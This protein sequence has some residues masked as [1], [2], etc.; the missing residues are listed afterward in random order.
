M[1]LHTE[2]YCDKRLF[3]IPYLNA[4]PLVNSTLHDVFFLQWENHLLSIQD[5][6]KPVANAEEWDNE[7]LFQFLVRVNK[8]AIYHE[9]CILLHIN[10]KLVQ[11]ILVQTV[12]QLKLDYLVS[13]YI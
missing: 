10:A 11:P 2:G 4:A 13:H 1:Y 8:P 5:A 7:S 3:V 12:F 9:N 6:Y